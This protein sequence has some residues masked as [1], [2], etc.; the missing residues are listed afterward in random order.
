MT[1]RQF[2]TYAGLIAIVIIIGSAL[3]LWRGIPKSDSDQVSVLKVPVFLP[4]TGPIAVYGQWTRDAMLLSAKDVNARS[5]V[6]LEFEFIDSKGFA[7][8]AV[9]AY[10]QRMALSSPPIVIVAITG[11]VFAI[12]PLSERNNQI[13]L[14]TVVTHPDVTQ[15]GNNVFRHFINKG[16]GAEALAKAAHK[17]GIADVSLIYINEEGGLAEKRAFTDAFTGLGGR[18]NHEYTFE[19]TT[20]DYRDIIARI[21][22]NGEKNLVVSG[23][24]AA[25]AQLLK[26]MREQQ[27]GARLLTSAD[28]VD[29]FIE[30]IAGPPLPGTIYYNPLHNP[31]TPVHHRFRAAYLKAYGTEPPFYSGFGYDLPLILEKTLQNDQWRTDATSLRVGL[32]QVTNLHGVYS[33]ITI[34]KDRD[35]SF[36]YP[37]FELTDAGESKKL[38][39]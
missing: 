15:R 38:W 2:V 21:R 26:Q 14:A 25:Y 6:K 33:D 13:L 37:V 34:G 36:E 39:P 20:T 35:S 31:D 17:L 8:E 22:A 11:P 12:A 28:V 32:L 7:R 16:T 27:L 18:I 30:G 5:P 24:G 23:Y 1:R 10:Q 3:F 29:P 9:T 4:L 19:K